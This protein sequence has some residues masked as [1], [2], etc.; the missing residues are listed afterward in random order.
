MGLP[1][2]NT[3][4]GQQHSFTPVRPQSIGAVACHITQCVLNDLYA[5]TYQMLLDLLKMKNNI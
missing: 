1:A 2:I 4:N 3:A 5:A